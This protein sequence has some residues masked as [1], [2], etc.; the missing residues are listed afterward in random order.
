MTR[1]KAARSTTNNSRSDQQNILKTTNAQLTICDQQQMGSP[2]MAKR[3]S[4]IIRK[5]VAPPVNQW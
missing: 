1:A 3:K 4:K 2:T 5:P